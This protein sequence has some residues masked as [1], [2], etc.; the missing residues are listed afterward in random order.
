MWSVT[1]RCG[2][3][4]FALSLRG[5]AGLARSTAWCCCF[6]PPVWGGRPGNRTIA[7][8]VSVCQ[9]SSDIFASPHPRNSE[10]K[11]SI[12]PRPLATAVTRTRGCFQGCDFPN[13]SLAPFSLCSPPYLLLHGLLWHQQPL[14][15][16]STKL[17]WWQWRAFRRESLCVKQV[18]VAEEHVT[19]VTPLMCWSQESRTVRSSS[20]RHWIIL[21]V[22]NSRG[23]LPLSWL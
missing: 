6:S 3:E 17:Y 21:S 5:S 14:L 7:E 4:E 20:A 10:G 23:F 15:S 19:I 12:L 1:H 8:T 18:V 22:T 16:F 11:S 9:I 13:S 2:A